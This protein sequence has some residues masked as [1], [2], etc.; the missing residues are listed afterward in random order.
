MAKD[1]VIW[2]EEIE[3]MDSKSKEELQL[4]RLQEIVEF[5][6]ENVPYYKRSFDK[7]NVKPEDIKTLKDIEKLPFTS[8]VD[9]R[10]E[11]PY[12][13]LAVDEDDI[14]EIHTTSGTTGKPTISAYTQEDI[15]IWAEISAR[16]LVM[17]GASKK[18][19][20][21][22]CYGYGLFTGGFGIHYGC[23]KLGATVLPI[24]AGNTKRQI[25]LIKNFGSTILT[26]TPSYAL[27]IAESLSKEGISLDEI[28]LKKGIFGAEMWTEEM[29]DE[30]EKR[31]G[32]DAF[33]IYGLTEIIGPGVAQECMEKNGLHIADDHFYPEIIDPDT[34]EVLGREEKGELVLTTLTKKGTPIIRFRT[35]DITYLMEGDCPC[36]RTGVR[37]SRVTGRSDDMVKVRGVIVYPSQIEAALLKIPDLDPHYKIIVSRPDILDEVEVQVEASNE[38]F[39]DEV[40]QIE[41]IEKKIAKLIHDEIGLRVNV[42]LVEP[43]TIERSE[44]K[45]V[46]LIDKRNFD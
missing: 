32:I 2:D 41:T 16:S 45:A 3:C 22:N 19:K 38:L 5:A 31:L 17:V 39:S 12:G 18:D 9:L 46:R 28:N 25:E 36:G 29:R 6:Y 27:Y 23:H 34:L 1:K 42:T 26:C 24:S 11:Y 15:D 37:M 21:Q 44:G 8:K 14:V 33:N 7:A 43:G 35:K 30:L 4:K 40:R 10:D 13:M 20:V